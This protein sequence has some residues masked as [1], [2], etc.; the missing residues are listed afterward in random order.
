[1][2]KFPF[3]SYYVGKGEVLLRKLKITVYIVLLISALALTI[4]QVDSFVKRN[5]GHENITSANKPIHEQT[6]NSNELHDEYGFKDINELEKASSVEDAIVTIFGSSRFLNPSHNELYDGFT[7]RIKIEEDN[8]SAII[9]EMI[10]FLHYLQKSDLLKTNNV[11][12][13]SK[14]H[15]GDYYEITMVVY[16]EIKP[17][18]NNPDYTMI[19]KI[20][21]EN[22]ELMDFADKPMIMQEIN[23]YGELKYPEP[24]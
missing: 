15:D 4:N 7:L 17:G 23:N 14:K 10:D 21:S 2:V 8:E 11:E 24:K 5:K 6:I 20:Y 16:P 22:V 19:W 1:M 12:G 3:L 9:V 18:M 13:I